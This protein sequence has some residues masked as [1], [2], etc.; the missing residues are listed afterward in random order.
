MK[1]KLLILT[2]FLF[3]LISCPWILEVSGDRELEN[4]VGDGKT[5]ATALYIHPIEDIVRYT[6]ELSITVNDNIRWAKAD[7]I[8]GVTYR[9]ETNGTGDPSLTIFSEDEYYDGLAGIGFNGEGEV[10]DN[11][12]AANSNDA[13][14]SYT[15]TASGLY[16]FKIILYAGSSWSGVFDYIIE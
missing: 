11:D 15:P 9:F 2:I 6:I 14:I 10:T 4:A 13:K 16:Y 12:G 1:I 7:L 3:S 8:S 5:I